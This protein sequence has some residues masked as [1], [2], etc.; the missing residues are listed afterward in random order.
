MDA[1]KVEGLEGQYL[2]GLDKAHRQRRPG[3][4][5]LVLFFGSTIGNFLPPAEEHFLQDVRA[6]L[7]PGDAL[8]LGTDLQKSISVLTLAYD[9]PVGVTAAF[10]RNILARMNR[11]LGGTFDLDS[12]THQARYNDQAHRIEMHLCSTKEQT[13]SIPGA[14]LDVT[15]QPGESIWTECSHKFRVED[16][17]P[18]AHRTGFQSVGQWV[19]G[20]WGLAQNLWL[21]V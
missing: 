5:L 3:Q 8:L 2:E 16:L 11:E 19:D 20:E 18:L 21:A 4:T 15:F 1:V 12:F 10:N 7:H 13:V 17:P 14:D 9:D 6:H